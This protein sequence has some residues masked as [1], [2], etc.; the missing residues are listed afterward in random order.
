MRLR[1]H[2][3][4]CRS[5]NVSVFEAARSVFSLVLPNLNVITQRDSALSLKTDALERVRDVQKT[6]AEWLASW[7]PEKLDIVCEPVEARST[8]KCL[9]TDLMELGKQISAQSELH[10]AQDASPRVEARWKA[11]CDHVK[12]SKWYIS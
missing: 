7:T 2:H 4:L 8:V 12:A 11:A 1:S 10:N 3:K 5:V 9:N 6:G